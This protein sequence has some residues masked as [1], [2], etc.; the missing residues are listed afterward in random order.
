M[1]AFM[2]TTPSAAIAS[3]RAQLYPYEAQAV[4]KRVDVN[5]H[6]LAPKSIRSFQI[7]MEHLF[8]FQR[9]QLKTRA[10]H[11]AG[12][13]QAIVQWM[14]GQLQ[15]GKTDLAQRQSIA[16]L[17]LPELPAHGATFIRARIRA[18]IGRGSSASAISAQA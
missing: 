4:N 7:R 3:L 12:Q 1:H 14:R 6:S 17:L 18:A 15:S 16:A 11:Q 10:Q 9:G 13:E 5:A 8:A 2:F